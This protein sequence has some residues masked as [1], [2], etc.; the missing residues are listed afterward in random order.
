MV[1]LLAKDP[2]TAFRCMQCINEFSPRS[3]LQKPHVAMQLL[4]QETHRHRC[5]EASTQIPGFLYIGQNRG[6]AVKSWRLPTS[7]RH[8]LFGFSEDLRSPSPPRSHAVTVQLD[9]GGFANLFFRHSFAINLRS[10]L[11]EMRCES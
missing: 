5:L 11:K 7:I 6:S 2:K 1:R 3:H 4:C 8:L 9:L 10:K